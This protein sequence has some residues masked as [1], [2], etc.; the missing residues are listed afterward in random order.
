MDY[1]S[2]FYGESDGSMIKMSESQKAEVAQVEAKMRRVQQKIKEE[3]VRQEESLQEYLK[4]H[5]NAKTEEHKTRIKQ[6]FENKHQKSGKDIKKLQVN[7]TQQAKM[8]K[9]LSCIRA[10][11]F[12]VRRQIR[13]LIKSIVRLTSQYILNFRD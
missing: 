1:C 3:T 8:V 5:S 7:L 12:P 9:V 11:A 6:L 4:L 2:I 10:R 13:Y